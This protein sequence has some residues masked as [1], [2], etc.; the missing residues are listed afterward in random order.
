MWNK[1][2]SHIYERQELRRKLEQE[3]ERTFEL[4]MKLEENSS[5]VGGKVWSSFSV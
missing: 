4:K 2:P 5:I 1:K 3:E